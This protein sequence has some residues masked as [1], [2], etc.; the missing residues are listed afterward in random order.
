MNTH[1]KGEHI[2]DLMLQ[3]SD[4]EDEAFNSKVRNLISLLV[5]KIDLPNVNNFYAEDPNKCANLFTYFKEM[6]SL[7]PD[8]LFIGE[9]PGIKGCYLT[10]IPFTSERMINQGIST[11]Q[12]FKS[13]YLINGNQYEHSANIIWGEVKKL[14]RPPL[15]WN[16]MPLHPYKL[17][18]GK[19]ENRPPTKQEKEWGKE[20]LLKVIGIFPD[21]RIYSIG[22]HSKEALQEICIRSEGH[23]T[24]PR[25]AHKF[26]EDF[27]K[28][29]G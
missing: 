21:V 12:I 29:F 28:Y 19:I 18:S 24:H 26:R 8:F 10:G 7:K 6:Y 20:I 16:V 15:F 23:L 1:K 2:K 3:Q 27:R 5:N 4:I 17:N 9:A 13:S 14:K 22:N 11:Q 25:L